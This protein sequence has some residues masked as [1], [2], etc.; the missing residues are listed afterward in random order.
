MRGDGLTQIMEIINIKNSQYFTKNND[1][2]YF[3]ILYDE[4]TLRV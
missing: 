3:I 2:Q 4:N 1:V